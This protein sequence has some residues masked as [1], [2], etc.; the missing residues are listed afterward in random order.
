MRKTSYTILLV[1]A[2]VVPTV[3]AAQTPRMGDVTVSLGADRVS[4][5]EDRSFGTV[6]SPGVG[7]EYR[8]V[9]PLALGV[10]V[11]RAAGLDVVPYA[12]RPPAGVLC[13]GGG[14]N[15]V[16]ETTT[17]S[18]TAAWYG[19]SNPRVQPYVLG[20]L[21]VVRSRS[22]NTFTVARAELW[23]VS[24]QEYADTGLGPTAGVGVR[25]LVSKR[26]VIK[27]EWRLAGG[28]ALGRANL[29]VMR[30]SV[31]VGYAW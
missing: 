19:T 13:A 14:R 23:T 16:L 30:T 31:A 11:H 4:R 5:F 3:A 28:T 9:K 29:S 10:D 7:F 22:V 25:F 6:A 2:T 1:A 15:G 8:P 18:V 20:G 17:T 24:E 26:F 27:P 21:S 12:C